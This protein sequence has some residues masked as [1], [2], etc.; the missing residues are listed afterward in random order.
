MMVKFLIIT[1]IDKNIE[2]KKLIKINT[3]ILL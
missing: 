1:K 3:L 2:N